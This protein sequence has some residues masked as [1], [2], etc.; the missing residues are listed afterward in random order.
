[1]INNKGSQTNLLMDH[2]ISKKIENKTKI[3]EV[4]SLFLN[5]RHYKYE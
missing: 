2:K 1:L 3:F 4:F 5:L